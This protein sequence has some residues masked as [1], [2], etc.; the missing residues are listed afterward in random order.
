VNR[1]GRTGRKRDI[2]LVLIGDARMGLQRRFMPRSGH[3]AFHLCVIGIGSLGNL[4]SWHAT[5]VYTGRCTSG[6][7]DGETGSG[8]LNMSGVRKI[9]A[10]EDG[11]EA[12]QRRAL[13]G[14]TN[15]RI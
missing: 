11:Q 6:G 12:I 3:E 5:L 13:P 1:S 8:K 7:R 2:V 14:K 4:S 10:G 9:D 15:H